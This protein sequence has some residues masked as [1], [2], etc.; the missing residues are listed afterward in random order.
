MISVVAL[1]YALFRVPARVHVLSERFFM[2]LVMKRRVLI[3]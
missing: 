2:T 1:S 3:N